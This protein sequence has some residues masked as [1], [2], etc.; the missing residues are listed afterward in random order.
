MSNPD[1]SFHKSSNEDIDK[2]VK[3][4]IRKN[5]GKHNSN[6]SILDDLREKYGKDKNIINA[7]VEKFNKKMNRV[8]KLSQ[9]PR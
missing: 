5:A 7:I 9:K 6:S 8:K 3:N 4:L 2:E 1:T